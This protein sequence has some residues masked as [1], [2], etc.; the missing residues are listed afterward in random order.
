MVLTVSYMFNKIQNTKHN[1]QLAQDYI[2]G[3]EKLGVAAVWLGAKLVRCCSSYTNNKSKKNIY[4]YIKAAGAT[5]IDQQRR[6]SG[7]E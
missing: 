5:H 3:E 4:I 6:L 1:H 2:K 7:A